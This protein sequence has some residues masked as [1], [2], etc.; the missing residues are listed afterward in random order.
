[1]TA[2][3]NRLDVYSAIQRGLLKQVLVRGLCRLNSDIF[4][5]RRPIIIACMPINMST[6]VN[7]DAAF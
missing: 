5:A 3:F 2:F 4:F 6:D 1:M 7:H